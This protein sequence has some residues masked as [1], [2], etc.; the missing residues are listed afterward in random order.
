MACEQESHWW[1]MARREILSSVI[2]NI[3]LKKDA[4]IL[5]IGCGSGGNLRMLSEHG[6]VE[7]TETDKFAREYARNISGINVQEGSL[8]DSMAHLEGK[9]DLVCLF[10][11]LEH[12]DQDLQAL[13]AVNKL[14]KNDGALLITVPAY[15]WLYGPHDKSHHHLRRY[16]KQEVMKKS[17]RANFDIKSI[18]YFNCLLFPVLLITRVIDILFSRN[19]S[20]GSDKPPPAINKILYTVFQF[21]K[22]VLKHAKFPF[23]ASII[24]TLKIKV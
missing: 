20:R 15:Q 17:I 22:R 23:G 2:A 13:T 1:F 19:D 24:A 6:G 7:A 5:E 4:R 10:D 9:F 21:E 14:V 11:V 3:G 18:S 16:S 12:I 8:P